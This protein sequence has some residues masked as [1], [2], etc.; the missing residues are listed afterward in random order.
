MP[1]SRGH[2]PLF[3]RVKGIE[4]NARKIEEISGLNGKKRRQPIEKE[5]HI[6]RRNTAP[7]TT[8]HL[9]SLGLRCGCCMCVS[10]LAYTVAAGHPRPAPA[11]S[12]R[13]GALICT[14]A[15]ADTWMW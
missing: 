9:S 6:R 11:A 2:K 1:Y 4:T 10:T 3:K 15:F 5:T 13:R 8:L 12:S 7:H 14:R